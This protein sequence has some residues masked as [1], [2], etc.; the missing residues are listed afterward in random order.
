MPRFV[1]IAIV[2]FLVISGVEGLAY[3]WMHPVRNEPTQ[4]VLSY[5]PNS[6]GV[7]SISNSNL[8]MGGE[9]SASGQSLEDHSARP[10]LWEDTINPTLLPQIYEQAAPI[11]RCSSGQ[12]LHAQLKDGISIHFGFF[13]WNYTDTGSVL[14][15]F[16][17]LPEACMG[18]IGMKLIS[19]ED[20]IRYLI[21]DETIIFDHTMFREAGK[22]GRSNNDFGEIV[23]AFR[24]VWVAG[25]TGSDVRRG[26]GGEDLNHLR[27]IRLKSAIGRFR[28]TH[29][30]VIQ[31]AVR[32]ASS[33]T[34]AWQ[35]FEGAL[36]KDLKFIVL[37]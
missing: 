3:W 1:T 11:L 37:N 13:E 35:A 36:L 23:H 21:G 9:I 19:K 20:S 18:S 4:L 5:Q 29:A 7:M 33:S 24:A 30:R 26:I 31:G 15:A 10:F 12:V 34:D 6:K 2:I 27:K 16:R 32:G 22:N 28:P 17:H 8:K 25:V 14:E